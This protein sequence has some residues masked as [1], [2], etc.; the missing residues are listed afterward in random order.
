[1]YYLKLNLL[2]FL[3]FLFCMPLHAQTDPKQK[4]FEWVF[5][6]LVKLDREMVQKVLNDT[7]G[8]RHYVDKDGD[9]KPEE[10]WFIDISPRHR[11]DKRPVLVRV[12]DE[13][14]NLRMGEE[15]GF[16]G[17]LY[18]A[19]WNADGNVDGVIEYKDLDSDGDVDEMA[20]FFYNPGISKGLSVWWGRDDGDDNLMWYDI[21]YIYDQNV[22]QDLTH[23]GSDET[24]SLF[25][26][27]P[28][29]KFWTP[30]IEIPFLFYDHD[31]DG[32]PEEVICVFGQEKAIYAL[33]HSFDLDND[34]TIDSPRDFDVSMSAYAPGWT[35]G[36]HGMGNAFE[37]ILDPEKGGSY[38][39]YP[40]AEQSET[41]TIRGIPTLPII[42]RNAAQSFFKDIVWSRVLMTWDENDLNMGTGS[43]FERWEGVIPPSSEDK[44]FE[45]PAVGG[46][47]CSPFNKRYELVL[48]PASANEFYFSPSDSRIHIKHSDRTWIKVDYD[49]D[50]KIDMYY[51]WTDT[52]KDGIL[53]KIE[54][55]IDGDG[56]FDDSWM[57][58][59][60]SIQHVQWNFRD[61]NKVYAPVIVNETPLVYQ[62]N[63]TLQQAVKTIRPDAEKAPAWEMIEHKFRT[64]PLS[65]ENC[66][67][68]LN[69]DASILYFM[70]IAADYDI[71]MLKKAY[72]NKT[73][74]KKF[75]IARGKND[76]QEMTRLINESFKILSVGDNYADWVNDLRMKPA[77][78]KRTAWDNTWYP[79]NWGW[80]SEK[81]AFR[82]YDGHFD[83]FGK[84]MDTLIFPVAVHEAMKSPGI[85]HT[86]KPWGMDIYHAGTTGGCGGLILYV[87]DI[88]YPVVRNKEGDPVFTGQ[89]LKETPDT[90]SLQFTATGVGPKDAPY[91][92]FIT[93][94]A[95]SGRYDSPIEVR[96]EGASERSLKL[97]I[98]M[99][100]LPTERYFMDKSLGITGVWGFHDP[101]IGWIGTGVIFPAD[102]FLYTDERPEEHRVVLKYNPGETVRYHIQGD[103]LRAHRYP[104][105]PGM[106]EWKEKL[107]KTVAIQKNTEEKNRNWEMKRNRILDSLQAAMGTLPSFKDL[108]SFDIQYRDSLKEEDYTRYLINFRVAENEYL[109]AYLYIPARKKEPN[110]K[111]PAMLALHQTMYWGKDDADGKTKNMGYARE[112]AQRGYVVISPDFPGFGDLSNYDFQNDR[113]LSGSMKG[114]FN[115][116]RCV[117]LLQT[118]DDVDPDRIGVI[119]HSLGGHNA[120][121]V[122]AFDT[123]LKVVVSS[124]GWTEFEYYDIGQRAEIHGGKLGPWAQ[125]YYMPLFRDKYH[126][127]IDSIPF[128]FHEIISLIA[129]RWFFSNSPVHD[130]Y[131][132]VAG[133]KVGI[134]RA[135]EAYH[136]FNAEE[137]LQIRY[138]IVGHDFPDEIRQEAYRF[139]DQAFQKVE[140]QEKK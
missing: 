83:L 3:V 101:E 44:G 73:F 20:I 107:I 117:D 7:H 43:K 63:S 26:I 68:L 137:R 18:V 100:V 111:Y 88:A 98:G 108:P 34:A 78:G 16:A 4:A 80:E 96:V 33:R 81:A 64:A 94:S 17:C 27:Q 5:G 24:F 86:E 114:I 40:G 77:P 140:N 42:K 30:K 52:N 99:N 35:L 31:D 36:E 105:A 58:D 129:P 127:N 82:C 51:L 89:L 125:K 15:P 14:G 38:H 134:D 60:S 119:G 91:N 76:L 9:G 69:S 37:L 41:L 67:R 121:F 79:P 29:E 65:I 47:P 1:M 75:D 130:D 126:L 104:V 97:G 28:E 84:R 62:L 102:R 49:F 90:V 106:K 115:H 2:V 56:K 109:P 135:K 112:L 61:M 8:K 71:A 120:M 85:Y 136:F 66:E 45:F 54:V 122:A 13:K 57:L 55:D 11:A 12:I 123:R 138:P 6:D 48:N 10:V 118:R 113:Y 22:C 39:L 74:W 128:N 59:V 95:I 116:I 46:P 124:A 87:D 72:K 132:D 23:F 131:F 70:R 53:D 32:Y 19:D 103:W 110:R 133:V 93:V 92:V 21:D 139:I 25:A 50:Q